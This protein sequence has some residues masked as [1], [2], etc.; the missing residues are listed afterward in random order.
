MITDYFYAVLAL[1]VGIIGAIYLSKNKEG[2]VSDSLLSN[3]NYWKLYLGSRIMILI[4]V[5]WII[6]LTAILITKL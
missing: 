3:L 6:K 5:L 4:G 1:I 2:K